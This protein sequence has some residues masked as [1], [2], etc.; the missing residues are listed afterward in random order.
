MSGFLVQQG[1]FDCNSVVHFRQD[2]KQWTRHIFRA[3]WNDCEKWFV[4]NKRICE[5]TTGGFYTTV[6]HYSII[7]SLSANTTGTEF[8]WFGFLL[9]FLFNR[10]RGSLWETPISSLEEVLMGIRYCKEVLL[11]KLP[12]SVAWRDIFII[13]VKKVEIVSLE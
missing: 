5:Q 1:V 7:P 2:L 12:P 6:T 9:F 4:K 3:V 8:T 10:V 11:E 13:S